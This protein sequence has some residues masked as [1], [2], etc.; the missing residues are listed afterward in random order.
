MM[1]GIVPKTREL[2]WSKE[3]DTPVCV[4]VCVCVK[5]KERKPKLTGDDH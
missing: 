4:C 2:G 1:E 3:R 5:E